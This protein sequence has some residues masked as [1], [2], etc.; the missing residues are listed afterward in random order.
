MSRRLGRPAKKRDGL[1]GLLDQQPDE[2]GRHQPVKRIRYPKKKK[3]KEEQSQEKL[4]ED[5][6]LDDGTSI[7]FDKIP[8][9]D[10]AF[11]TLSGDDAGLQ[12]SLIEGD[13]ESSFVGSSFSFIFL[14][15]SL[16]RFCSVHPRPSC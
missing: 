9:D 3:V 7:T 14:S 10:A 6:F 8:F 1:Q 11:G 2:R 13:R 16:L 5:S 12:Q 15:L 4:S